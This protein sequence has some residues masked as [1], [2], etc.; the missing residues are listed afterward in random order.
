MAPGH[1][2]REGGWP[3]ATSAQLLL[4]GKLQ[5]PLNL[6]GRAYR[7]H[8]SAIS[9][10]KSLVV[11]SSCSIDC[12]RSAGEQSGHRVRRQVEVGKVEEVE[13]GHGRFD[14]EPLRDRVPPS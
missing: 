1:P 12:P 9:N 11:E 3:G 6:A 8:A 4:E 14:S 10:S 7:V 13:Y 5:S 2:A